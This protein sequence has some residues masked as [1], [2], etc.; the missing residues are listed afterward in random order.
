[1]QPRPLASVLR[2]LGVF[3]CLFL[4][5]KGCGPEPELLDA[6]M[7]LYGAKVVE[8]G[9]THASFEWKTNTEGNTR[10]DFALVAESRTGNAEKESV[11]DQNYLPHFQF[12]GGVTDPDVAFEEVSMT[13]V[14]KGTR[15]H[16]SIRIDDLL[17]NR[18]YV[19]TVSSRNGLGAQQREYGWELTFT[20]SPP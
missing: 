16:H 20:T 12:R 7:V 2:L 4:C 1:M 6:P 19:A 10:V 11:S 14:R 15:K 13:R 17:P 8:V 18:T 5:L 9:S 3:G